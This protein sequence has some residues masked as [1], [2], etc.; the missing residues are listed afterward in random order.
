MTQQQGVSPADHATAYAGLA[1]RSG[2]LG[3][4]PFH[5]EQEED[6]GKGKDNSKDA[7]TANAAREEAD[8]SP[9]PTTRKQPDVPADTGGES[10]M[11]ALHLLGCGAA[12]LLLVGAVGLWEI[13]GAIALVIGVGVIGVVLLIVMVTTM[14]K[15]RRVQRRREQDTGGTGGRGLGARSRTTRHSDSRSQYG[16]TPGGSSTRSRSRNP[17]RRGSNRDSSS[18]GGGGRPGSRSSRSRGSRSSSAS[19][20]TGSKNPNSSDKTSTR[21]RNPLSRNPF[22]KKNGPNG[23]PGKPG[24]TSATKPTSTKPGSPGKPGPS[25]SRTTGSP[26]SRSTGNKPDKQRGK[27]DKGPKDDLNVGLPSWM[28]RDRSRWWDDPDDRR[29]QSKRRKDDV[30]EFDDERKGRRRRNREERDDELDQND[31]GRDTTKKG[32]GKKSKSNE[33][34]K[35]GGGVTIH[36]HSGMPISNGKPPKP[37]KQDKADSGSEAKPN[38]EPASNQTEQQKDTGH[39][40]IPMDD[41]GF[42]SPVFQEPPTNNHEV[43]QGGTQ[44]MTATHAPAATGTEESTRSTRSQLFTD[45]AK[46][47]LAEANDK[48]QALNDMLE[49]AGIGDTFE[50]LE[51]SGVSDDFKLEARKL[52]KDAEELKIAASIWA[53]EANK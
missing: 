38:N 50:G 17:F 12:V 7:N 48:E 46:A 18:P 45:K 1:P 31:G 15:V 25:G 36:P 8:S 20:G 34:I 41:S 29:R 28:R 16:S 40:E 22:S 13:G 32:G 21:S 3:S 52:K 43:P 24:S 11:S 2:L 47:A 51:A 42:S 4:H 5:P 37:A 23:G 9:A 39:E 6:T 19:P 53:A 30:D 10:E 44:H 14:A 49:H 33:P 27:R 35:V 26:G